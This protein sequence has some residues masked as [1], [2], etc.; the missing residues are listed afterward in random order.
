[1]A[2][3][4]QFDEKYNKGTCAGRWTFRPGWRKRGLSETSWQDLIRD[5]G[6]L[7]AVRMSL[8]GSDYLIQM[9]FEGCAYHAFKASGVRPPSRVTR[10]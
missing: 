4:L 10:L 5:L 6:Q 9:D 2:D 1:M 8:D 7:Q 3:T